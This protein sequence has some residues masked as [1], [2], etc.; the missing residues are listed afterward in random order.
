MYCKRTAVKNFRNIKEADVSFSDGVN[1]LVGD[2]AQGK[3][4]LLEAIFFTSVGRSFRASNASEMI[5]F[6]E[7]S[8]T[9]SV[10]YLCEGRSRDDNLT[11]TL[12]TDKKKTVEKNHLKLEKMSDIVGSF[13]AV[14]FCPE[15]AYDI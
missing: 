11:F 2:N 14:L 3:T 12:F 5:R 10:D 13:R 6:G 15:R 7:K 8:A 1:I 4:N 9:V